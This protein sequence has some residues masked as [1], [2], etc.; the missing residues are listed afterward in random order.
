MLRENLQDAGQI[1]QN[2]LGQPLSVPGLP[3]GVSLLSAAEEYE[4]IEGEA[5]AL[6]QVM[7][8][9]LKHPEPTEVLLQELDLLYNDLNVK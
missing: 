4:P 3:E 2:M 6:S 5:S 7:L 1:I 8:S 9:F